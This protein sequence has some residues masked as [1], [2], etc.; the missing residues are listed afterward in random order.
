V[1]N[2]DA[3]DGPQEPV[4]G[5]GETANPGKDADGSDAPK[6]PDGPADSGPPGHDETR[7][8]AAEDMDAV[9]DAD[10]GA[11]EG[12]VWGRPLTSDDLLSAPADDG[13]TIGDDLDEPGGS[14]K[15]SAESEV[16]DEGPPPPETAGAEEPAVQEEAT[17][18]GPA[19]G[20]ARPVEQE[21]PETPDSGTSQGDDEPGHTTMEDIDAADSSSSGPEDDAANNDAPDGPQEPVNGDGETANPGKDADGS[22]GPKDPGEPADSGPPGHDETR[23]ATAEDTDAIGEENPIP[24]ETPD[25]ESPAAASQADAPDPGEI[26]DAEPSEQAPATP[27]VD[28][29]AEAPD[30]AAAA[31]RATPVEL[32]EAL[33][34]EQ[35]SVEVSDPEEA[36]ASSDPDRLEAV[37]DRSVDLDRLGLTPEW[38]NLEPDGT[39]VPFDDV[40]LMAQGS[41]GNP[42]QPREVEGSPQKI[43][44]SEKT[45]SPKE[46]KMAEHL[47]LEGKNVKA[48]KES[49]TPGQKTPDSL[50]DG[51]P[52]EFKTLQPDAS[53]NSVKNTLNTAKK[54]AQDAVVDARG[55]GLGESGAHE[56]LA[57]FLRNNPPDRMKSIR[58]IG[59]DYIIRWP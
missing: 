41:Q 30:F 48:L 44:E 5:D 40:P 21:I 56:G 17:E 34:S 46:R 50:V 54:Q 22:D 47:Q 29:S 39:F 4:N 12:D 23:H 59:D 42:S 49:T 18:A 13:S 11:L 28:H 58:I 51:V 2:N 31:G 8:T 53:P 55:S 24:G 45:F 43:D 25:Q 36:Q 10:D 35:P 3:P 6:D 1:A 26:A 37:T 16:A 19:D 32:V 57:K 14:G 33:P 20:P 9:D 38:H 7:H 52:T 15:P 27:D